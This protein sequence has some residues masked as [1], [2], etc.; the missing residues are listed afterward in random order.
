MVVLTCDFIPMETKLSGDPRVRRVSPIEAETIFEQRGFDKTVYI[1][2]HLDGRT[3]HEV[4]LDVD[5]TFGSLGGHGYGVT[6]QK[7]LWGLWAK[8]EQPWIS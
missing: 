1:G 7:R 4:R 6:F 3:P 5:Y 2:L 8:A